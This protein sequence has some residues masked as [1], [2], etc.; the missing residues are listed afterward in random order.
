MFPTCPC[1]KLCMSISI[2]FLSGMLIDRFYTTRSAR[3]CTCPQVCVCVCVCVCECMRVHVGLPSRAQCTPKSAPSRAQCPFFS[4]FLKSA[5]VM[6]HLGLDEN[7]KKS[8]AL[9]TTRSGQLNRYRY[10][11]NEYEQNALRTFRYF[12]TCQLESKLH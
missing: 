1:N 11:G 10:Y 9:W 3:T 12:Q 4:F 7:Q 6:Q 2:R 8:A 5:S